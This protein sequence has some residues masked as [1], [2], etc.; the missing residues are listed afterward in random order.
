M[1]LKL[2]RE[3]MEKQSRGNL[4]DM[5][6]RNSVLFGNINFSSLNGKDVIFSISKTADIIPKRWNWVSV[7]C[8]GKRFDI[9]VG[10][11]RTKNMKH[12]DADPCGV[13][14]AVPLN[15]LMMRGR[16][17][18]QPELEWE[19]ERAWRQLEQHLLWGDGDGG[20]VVAVRHH[21][22]DGLMTPG[23][24]VFTGESVLHLLEDEESHVIVDTI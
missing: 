11:E 21:V 15:P 17:P 12:L 19:R 6:R 13:G 22:A 9:Y 1:F 18:V 7:W 8:V 2:S 4:R 20:C 16:R 14:R 5:E 10:R 24:L 3:T 23:I